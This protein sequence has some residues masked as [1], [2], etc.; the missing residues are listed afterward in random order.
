MRLQKCGSFVHY[1]W[2]LVFL[3]IHMLSKKYFMETIIQFFSRLFHEFNA[4][5]V[6]FFFQKE[7][8]SYWLQTFEW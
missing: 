3:D 5:K 4:I 7:N 8:Y 2:M 6:L 1:S